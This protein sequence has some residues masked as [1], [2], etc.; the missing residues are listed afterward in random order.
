[1]YLQANDLAE[2][3]RGIEED[4]RKAEAAVKQSKQKDYYKVLGIPRNAK[5]KQIK[6]A[7]REQALMWHPDK[8]QGE[9]EKVVA[10]T[11]FQ[12]VAEAYEVLSDDEK[13]TPYR[14]TLSTY[15]VTN[16]SNSLYLTFF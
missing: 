12:L 5:I 7:Y 3:D 8:H 14:Y 15:P 9:E 11:K 10:E 1:M 2:G 13:V 6:K 16:P 4:L